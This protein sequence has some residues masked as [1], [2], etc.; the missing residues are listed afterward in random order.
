M[1]QVNYRGPMTLFFIDTIYDQLNNNRIAA[2]ERTAAEDTRDVCWVGGWDLHI[3]YWLNFRPSFL[4]QHKFCSHRG[5]PSYA[6]H[7]HSDI[8]KSKHT[9]VDK[10]KC[11][12]TTHPPVPNQHNTFKFP[13]RAFGKKKSRVQK[14]SC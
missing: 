6:M 10:G 12:L 3:F 8:I 5:F 7:H 11:P 1:I 4:P 2:L 14:C 13:Q 9:M